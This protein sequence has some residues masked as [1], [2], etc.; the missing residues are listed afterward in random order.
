MTKPRK[1]GWFLPV[2]ATLVVVLLVYLG[3]YFAIVDHYISD[4]RVKVIYVPFRRWTEGA[5]GFSYRNPVYGYA[6]RFFAPAHWLDRR[7][8]PHVWVPFS[9]F[10]H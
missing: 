6:E 4:S 5:D 2:L 1:S 8:R 3:A 7:L 9:V 10:P